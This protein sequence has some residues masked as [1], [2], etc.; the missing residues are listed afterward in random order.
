MKVLRGGKL[1]CFSQGRYKCVMCGRVQIVKP[2]PVPWDAPCKHCS[3]DLLVP[4]PDL[5]LSVLTSVAASQSDN[6]HKKS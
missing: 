2:E 3:A 4:E 1:I 6:R 5:P